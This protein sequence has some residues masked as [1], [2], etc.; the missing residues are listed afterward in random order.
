[1]VEYEVPKNEDGRLKVLQVYD[2]E[3]ECNPCACI[4]YPINLYKEDILLTVNE[5]YKIKL[6]QFLQHNK[7]YYYFFFFFFLGLTG[8]L[9]E[10]LL[11][12]HLR[13]IP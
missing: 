2:I 12:S 8:S 11:G 9:Q 4:W 5:D 13:G 6:W 3:Q 7:S 10:D 1:M